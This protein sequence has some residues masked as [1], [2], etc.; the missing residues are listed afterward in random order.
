MSAFDDYF[1]KNREKSL[2]SSFNIRLPLVFSRRPLYLYFIKKF[3]NPKNYISKLAYF[4]ITNKYFIFLENI[5]RPVSIRIACN[6][7]LKYSPKI[8]NECL[9]V[10]DRTIINYRNGNEPELA[11]LIDLLIPDDGVFIDIGANWGYFS[12]FLALRNGFKGFIHSFEPI[13]ENISLLVDFKNKF[14]LKSIHAYKLA[15]ANSVSTQ[16]IYY[17]DL[18]KEGATLL[19]PSDEKGYEIDP[20]WGTYRS[21][22]IEI[23]KLDSFIFDRIDFLKI[24]VEGLEYECI[25]GS[26][27]QIKKHNPYIF[28]ESHFIEGNEES[29]N[30]SL[31]L[32][33]FL[34]KLGY[35]F[36][37]PS[38][39]QKKS[40]FFVGIGW[41][42]DMSHFALTP[43]ESNDRKNFGISILN[44]FACHQSKVSFLGNPFNLYFSEMNNLN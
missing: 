16:R 29:I 20:S 34:E 14:N 39:V 15:L 32:F 25:Q 44:V 11:H 26:K 10:L 18:L 36:Y 19:L 22:D 2:I 43:F 9:R 23:S 37:L 24:D 1:E 31:L 27:E 8:A 5:L 4:C 40:T 21:A 35:K 17:Y 12:L 6:N 3:G 42:F 33:E 7:N 38:W 28:L 41:G 30:K 13:E